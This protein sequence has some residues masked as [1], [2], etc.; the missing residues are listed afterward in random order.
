[1][2]ID[3]LKEI[4]SRV[5]IVSV[6]DSLG[7]TVN[8]AGFISCPLH[9]ER[10]AS[11]RLYQEQGRFYCFGC[12]TGGDAIDLVAAVRGVSIYEA[13]RWLNDSYSLGVD[14]G[15]R[16]ASNKIRRKKPKSP[17]EIDAEQLR[18]MVDYI[19]DL[20]RFLLQQGIRIEVLENNI[21][22]FH[23]RLLD[24]DDLRV[25]APRVFYGRYRDEFIKYD[26]AERRYFAIRNAIERSRR[27][28]Q[29]YPWDEILAILG[30]TRTVSD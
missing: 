2:F 18:N 5:D 30:R 6:A 16:Q 20:H 9:N 13:A 3:A 26:T 14:L 19:A 27:N 24:D 15:E 12:N 29:P 22:D 21:E 10:T 23:Q 7:L 11:C 8:R 17:Q 4:S 1:M 28:G 25:S